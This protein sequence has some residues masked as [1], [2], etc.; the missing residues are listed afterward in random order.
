MVSMVRSASQGPRPLVRMMVNSELWAKR[1]I[2]KILPIST[3]MGSSSYR[4]L[5]MSSV[6]VSSAIQMV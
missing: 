3:A 5:G 6:T 4:W 2:T 1:A